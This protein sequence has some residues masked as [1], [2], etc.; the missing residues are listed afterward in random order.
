[1]CLVSLGSRFWQR[2]FLCFGQL[3]KEARWYSILSFCCSSFCDHFHL[4]FGCCDV[5]AGLCFDWRHS[6]SSYFEVVVFVR[7]LI[8]L[9]SKVL[10]D[11]I[12]ERSLFCL[13]NVWVCLWAFALFVSFVC[14]TCFEF[15]LALLSIFVLT[16][17]QLPLKYLLNRLSLFLSL[18]KETYFVSKFCIIF[19]KRKLE[20]LVLDWISVL[21]FEHK[22]TVILCLIEICIAFINVM[23]YQVFDALYILDTTEFGEELVSFWT[24]TFL[25]GDTFFLNSIFIGW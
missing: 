22:L 7:N 19:V 12:V 17:F 4:S 5:Q 8:S 23:F 16:F 25:I 10:D 15:N 6:S 1:M 13:T 14:F 3:S 24:T 21:L 11:K 18:Q 20:Q 9:L 2:S